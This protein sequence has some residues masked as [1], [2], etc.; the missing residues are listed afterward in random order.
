MQILTLYST[1]ME[2]KRNTHECN[3][4]NFYSLQHHYGIETVC[5]AY[6]KHS[7][8]SSLQHH[9]GIETLLVV[10]V[11]SSSLFSLQHHYGIETT[12]TSVDIFI[13]LVS[14]QHHYG[15]ETYVEHGQNTGYAPL[16]STIMELKHG[17]DCISEDLQYS[18]YSTIMEL[19]RNSAIE[20][21]S[22]FNSLQHHYGIETLL[23]IIQRSSQ[24]LFIAPLWN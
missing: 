14:L 24:L 13:D 9:Y 15:I 2:L 12:H 21:A 20:L 7:E 5:R 1:I 6:R 16:Y 3:I 19:K 22:N 8:D 23:L 18:L 4:S 17:I 11:V 10:L